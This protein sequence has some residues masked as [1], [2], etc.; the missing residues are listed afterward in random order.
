M[1]QRGQQDFFREDRRMFAVR[2]EPARMWCPVLHSL[3][4]Q[5][6][7]SRLGFQPSKRFRSVLSLFVLK[8]WGFCLN[9]K[10]NSINMPLSLY[11][12]QF[13]L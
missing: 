3:L 10:K 9:V 8:I 1:K 4:G 2:W 12:T 5:I 13:A 7:L 6:D 11:F